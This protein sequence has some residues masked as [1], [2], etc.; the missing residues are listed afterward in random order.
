MMT[1]QKKGP[2]PGEKWLTRVRI[3]PANFQYTVRQW[4]YKVL[5]SLIFAKWL[6]ISQ[7]MTRL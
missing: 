4:L 1:I 7:R 5:L 3:F 2:H 6:F